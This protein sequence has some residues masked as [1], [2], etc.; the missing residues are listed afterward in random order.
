MKPAWQFDEAGEPAESSEMVQVAITYTWNI[1]R[2]LLEAMSG[3]REM[4]DDTMFYWDSEVMSE[5]VHSTD[6]TE[7]REIT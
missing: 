4:S 6:P 5:L 7:V 3:E 1:P 2:W